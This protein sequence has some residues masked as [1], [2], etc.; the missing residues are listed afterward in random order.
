MIEHEPLFSAVRSDNPTLRDAH[1]LA[2]ESILGFRDYT[3]E[4]QGRGAAKLR[5]RDPDESERLGEDRFVYLWLSEVHF[6]PAEKIFSGVFFEVPKAFQQWHNVG[7]RL[8]F[9][10]ED[11]FD[12][13]LLEDGHLYGG[14]TLR[15]TRANLPPDQQEAYDQNIGVDV[16][17]D[18]SRLPDGH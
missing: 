10:P 14:F 2:S 1:R 16:Y 6:H 11:V 4:H 18:P 15:V 13:M 5:F 7:E 3:L 12:W 17:E 9:D 8:G